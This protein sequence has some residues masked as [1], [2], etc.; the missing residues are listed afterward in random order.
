MS[1]ETIPFQGELSYELPEISNH[2][3]YSNYRSLIERIDGIIKISGLDLSF[4]RA[5]LDKVNIKLSGK[6]SKNIVALAVKAYRCTLCKI[7]LKKSYRELSIMLADSTLLQRFCTIARIDGQIQIPTKSTLQRYAEM[8]DEA[9]LRTQV[10]LLNSQ[11]TEKE[12]PLELQDPFTTDDVYIDATCMKANIHFP[13]DWVLMKDCMMTILKAIIVI[14]KHGLK[15]RIKKPEAFM[16]EINAICMSMTSIGRKPGSR[17]ERK[18]MFRKLKKVSQIIKQH[19]INY[20]QRLREDRESKT[21]LSEA[22]AACILRRLDKMI[23]L[24]PKAIKQANSRIISNKVIK[25]EDK[26]LSAYHDNVNVIKRG[27]AGGQFE[28]GNPLFIAE[29][30][31]GVIL[32]W[33]LYETDVKE[34]QSTKESI[35]RLTEDLNYEIK[36][37]TGERGCQSEANDKLLQ[38]K[39]I[40]SG[41]CPRDP[42]QFIE[43]MEDP[44]FRKHQKRRAQTE[45]RIGIFKNSILDGSLYERNIENKQMKV[46]WAVLAHNLWCIAR[47]PQLTGSNTEAA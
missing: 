43:K 24:L 7:F 44:S 36:S 19:G 22:E 20:A 34:P 31:D 27:K 26:I 40:T 37:L 9:F 17:K 28:Y 15:H 8:F 4:A 18:T 46:A 14:R 2:K 33:R 16:S 29:Q 39:A 41:L 42:A 30:K 5:Q 21:D 45:A 3:D 32:D 38:K 47:L 10:D 6:Q 13:V 1:V 35:K 12:N 25:N 11:A 23:N